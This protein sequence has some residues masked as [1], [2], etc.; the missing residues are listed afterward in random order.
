M[1]RTLIKARI[2]AIVDFA[3]IAKFLD[4]P[5]KRYSSGMRL[6]LGFA[7]AANLEAD[8]ML[9]DEVLA[10]GDLEFQKKCLEAMD[11]LHT[12]GRTVLFVSHNLAAIEHLCSRAI[13]I[14]AGQVKFDG[15]AKTAIRTY[16]ATFGHVHGQRF[17]LRTVQSRRG[18]GAIQFTG[19]ELLDREGRPAQAIASG[20]SVVVR[21][22]FAASQ[23]IQQ[24]V[25]GLQVHSHLGTLIAYLHTHN[26][27]LSIPQ[28]EPGLGYMDLEID[29]LNL[30][31]GRYY[32]SLWLTSPGY[33]YYDVLDHCAVLDMQ[34][35]TRYGLGVSLKDAL[36]GLPCRWTLQTSLDAPSSNVRPVVLP[37][38]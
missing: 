37:D 31:P 9:V 13:W 19:L 12:Q 34:Q 18:N 10:V 27:G 21:L 28:I 15:D 5:I 30:L 38:A 2:D 35:S 1:S 20:D 23:L 6:R 17:D 14:D 11:D 26:S 29:D 16:M 3:G 8:V 22:A 36:I 4:T 25:F 32:L 33:V 7:V 24:P